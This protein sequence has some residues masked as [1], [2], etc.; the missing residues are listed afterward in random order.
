MKRLKDRVT[1]ITGASRGLGKALALRFAAEGS[2]IV[3]TG[4]SYD[5]M[6]DICRAILD[7]GGKGTAV[8]MNVLD[9]ESI[10]SAVDDAVERYGRIDILINNAGISMVSPS[11]N[12][13][14]EDWN[15]A[16]GTNLTGVFF[17]CQAVARHMIDKGTGGC[18]INISSTFGKTPV[19]LRAA[20]CASKAGT[21][22]ITRVLA[23]EWAKKN[24][25]VNAIAPGYLNTEFIQDLSRQGKLDV[26]ALKRRIPT[27]QDRRC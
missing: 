21:D 8:R 5:A 24:I 7:S 11:E 16:I 15:N 10:K 12:L 4:R 2:T 26:E 22:M 19:P 18:I 27:G 14:Y 1:M 25:R 23:A 6:N 17:C 3:L 13:S 9:P 20:Y